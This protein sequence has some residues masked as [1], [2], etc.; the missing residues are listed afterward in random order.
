MADSVIEKATEICK[1][2]GIL[3]IPPPNQLTQNNMDAIN[4]SLKGML[5]DT[6]LDK[7]LALIQP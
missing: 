2:L 6:G 3:T 4:E 5:K 7:Y 1:T